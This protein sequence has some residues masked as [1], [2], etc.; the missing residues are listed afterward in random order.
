MST[1]FDY[2]QQVLNTTSSISNGIS[3]LV[4]Y[5]DINFP[6][7]LWV[8][9]RNLDFESDISKLKSWLE[10]VLSNEPPSQEINGFWFGLYNPVLDNGEVS[11]RLYI[12]GSTKFSREDETGDWAAW[13]ESSY[14]PEGR[15]ADSNV[16]H[17]IFR[18][19]DQTRKML[20]KEGNRE[21]IDNL[22]DGEYILCIGYASLVVR[23]ICSSINPKLLFGERTTRSVA[24]GYDSGDFIILDSADEY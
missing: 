9:I 21:E 12:S 11:C 16:L 1:D 23:T 15:Y 17:Q 6:N 19:I 14:I 2:I 20:I 4:D 10:N 18:L 8:K 22:S 7:S 3:Q 13:D 5:C 24:V